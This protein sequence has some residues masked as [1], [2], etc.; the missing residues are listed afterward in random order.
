MEARSERPQSQSR[1][2]RKAL[3]YSGR[4][5]QT[6]VVLMRN[7]SKRDVEAACVDCIPNQPGFRPCTAKGTYVRIST[8]ALS[9]RL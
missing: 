5:W 3:G 9:L 4:G 8:D 7:L 1:V 6:G 2:E